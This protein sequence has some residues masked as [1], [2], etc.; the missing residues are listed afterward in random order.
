MA[1]SR[2]TANCND[3]SKQ[4]GQTA[5]YWASPTS[6]LISLLLDLL[7]N[8]SDSLDCVL[9]RT[10]VDSKIVECGLDLILGLHE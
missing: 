1:S 5:S 7:V 4:V 10:V 6:K 2:M 8:F 3:R 9:N